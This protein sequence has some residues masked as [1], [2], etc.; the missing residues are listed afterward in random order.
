MV[1]GK[2]GRKNHAKRVKKMAEKIQGIKIDKNM[3][4]GLTKETGQDPRKIERKNGPK[5]FI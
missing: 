5:M 4:G 2:N 3:G 1:I